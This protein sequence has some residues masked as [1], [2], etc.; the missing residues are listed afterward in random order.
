[1]M[2]FRKRVLNTF[3]TVSAV[4]ALF[5]VSLRAAQTDKTSVQGRVQMPEKLPEGVNVEG[6]CLDNV[7]LLLEG[8]YKHPRMPYPENWSDM[9][10]D[11][12]S[13]W[14]SN[15]TNSDGY[16]AY[17]RKVDE[18]L[19]KRPVFKTKVQED[20]SFVF[21]D[22]PLSWYQL[23]AII[24]H[25]RAEGSPDYELARAF[26]MRQ[27]IIKNADEP[28]RVGTMTLELKSVLMP[29]DLAPDWEASGYDGSKFSLSD[30]RG[31]YVLLDFWATWCGPCIGEIPNLEATH[32]A[33]GGKRLQVIGLSVD[34]TIDIASRFLKKKPSAYL[35]G[36]LGQG[37]LYEEI[38]NAYGI[39]SIP[40]IWLIDPDGKI[41]ARDLLGA[42]MPELVRKAM[43]KDL[44]N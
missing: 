4:V 11:E 5:D 31:R 36:F 1:M 44:P 34:N 9:T 3:L 33:L 40:S 38:S 27:F 30:F 16:E 32:D 10:P 23:R 24:M 37:E 26:K 43:D 28:Y 6:L 20:G 35:Q 21:K 18:A 39:E 2:S 14:R 15:F 12:R 7:I 29:G 42:S 13:K 19:L 22:I 25:P 17:K 41:V 8:K